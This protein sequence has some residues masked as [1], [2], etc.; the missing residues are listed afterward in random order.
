MLN[1]W[2][3]YAAGEW[4]IP[5]VIAPVLVVLLS[6]V[7][8]VMAVAPS[9]LPEVVQLFGKLLLPLVYIANFFVI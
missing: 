3:R 5:I 8:V 2:K 9:G 1:N 6:V 4:Q 7:M